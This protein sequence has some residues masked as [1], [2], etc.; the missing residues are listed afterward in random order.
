M[1]GWRASVPQA[2]M[3]SIHQVGLAIVELRVVGAVGT[4][5]E[6]GYGGG[7][8]EGS[9]GADGGPA[10]VGVA[11]GG[12]GDDGGESVG[13]ELDEGVGGAVDSGEAGAVGDGGRDREARAD[14][15]MLEHPRVEGRAVAAELSEDGFCAGGGGAGVVPVPED[16]GRDQQHDDPDDDEQA[17]EG[18]GEILTTPKAPVHADV[19]N[20]PRHTKPPPEFIGQ[21]D[22]RSARP[23]PGLPV[24]IVSAPGANIRHGRDDGP[25]AVADNHH[26]ARRLRDGSAT[27]SECLRMRRPLAV[28]RPSRP[29]RVAVT[30]IADAAEHNRT[31]AR[32]SERY[33]T[34]ETPDSSE[35]E[36]NPARERCAY[37]CPCRSG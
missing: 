17:V 23:V 12:G 28:R 21:V 5:D 16:E 35:S 25:A 9:A 13:S 26:A 34:C 29:S 2:M 8:A 14:E 10:D 11:V 3:A 7:L 30:V 15:L 1:R 19:T 27:K 33:F 31:T 6:C 20:S 32:A 18:H 4:G 22:A 36:S 24:R 37:A